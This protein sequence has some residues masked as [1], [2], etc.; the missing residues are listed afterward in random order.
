MD[1]SS[2]KKNSYKS[3][4]CAFSRSLLCKFL[5]VRQSLVHFSLLIVLGIGTSLP[6]K[7][8]FDTPS[9]R[10]ER[11]KQVMSLKPIYYYLV[12][13]YNAI[14]PDEVIQLVGTHQIGKKLTPVPPTICTYMLAM[15]PILRT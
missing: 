11:L 9:Q 14:Y 10:Y 8:L 6:A 1:Y 7:V 15:T 2:C 12:M 13:Y 3:Y 4:L 5:F